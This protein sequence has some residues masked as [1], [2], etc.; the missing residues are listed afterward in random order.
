MREEMKK[1]FKKAFF[2]PICGIQIF[3]FTLLE[4][5]V[6]KGTDAHEYYQCSNCCKEF[7]TPTEMFV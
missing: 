7:L 6:D 3:D 1:H 2:C 5:K 4:R